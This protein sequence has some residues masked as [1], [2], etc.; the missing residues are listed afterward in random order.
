[1]PK[2]I[3]FGIAKA[4][5]GQP[6]TDRTVFTAFDQFIGTPAYMSPEQAELTSL[7]IDTRSDIYSLGVVMK[8]LEKDRARRY[9]T[10]NGL[11]ADL[12]R[13]LNNEPVVARPPSTAYLVKKY[14]RRHR[15][16]LAV[17]ASIAG[18]LIAGTS[19]STW[20]AIVATRAKT[21]AIQAKASEKAQRLAAQ[22]ERDKAQRAQQAEAQARQQ[23]DLDK[24]GARRLL[25]VA[26]M[27]LAQQAWE[28]NNIDRLRQLLEETKS[29]PDLGFE[30]FYWQR[31]MHLA[32]TTLRGHLETVRSAAFSPDGQRIVTASDDGAAIVWDTASGRQLLPL[33][34][35]KTGVRSVAFSPE[36]QRIVTGSWDTT[37]K[38]WEA[39][40]GQEFLTLTGHVASIRAVAFSPDSQ[41]IV[42]TSNGGTAMVWN[43]TSGEILLAVKRAGAS[44]AFSPDGQRILSGG[45]D[46]TIYDTATVWEAATGRE[47]LTLKG[48]GAPAAFSLD[49]QRIVTG[50]GGAAAKV[51]EAATGRELL[52]LKGH[53]GTVAAVAFSRDGQRIVTGSDDRTVRV[54]EAASG[55]E[56][57]MLQ[58]HSAPI[59]S[60]MFS[61]DGQRIVTGSRDH[62]AKVWEAGSD[63]EWFALN[64]H[65]A[66][67]NSAAFSPDGQRV[68]TGLDDRTAKVWEVTSGREL[69]AL[70]AHRAPVE[71]VAYS[72]D[73]QRILTGSEDQTA[74]VWEAASGREL[75]RLEGHGA[76][77]ESVAFSPD[78]Q[79]IVTG[80]EDQTARVWEVASGRELLPLKWHTGSI[81]SV[82][83]SPDGQRIVTGSVDQTA[84]VWQAARA[85]QVA[86]WQ[87]EEQ[88]AEQHLAVLERERTLKRERQRVA[89]IGDEGSIKRWLIL[90]PIPLSA[91]QS[92][93]Q[94]LDV[95]QI[96]GEAQ[97][98]PRMGETSAIG[99]REFKWREV[100]LRDYL[101]DSNAI[102]GHPT[103]RSVGY[104]VCY[105]RSDAEQHG[106]G[107]LVCSDTV[108]KV[109]L[110][111]EQVHRYA[112]GRS[113]LADQ[114][115]VPEVTLHAGLNVLVFKVVGWI[116]NW[117]GS[118]RFTD[119]QGNPVKGIKVTL[120]PEAK[121]RP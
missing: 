117:M 57:F 28:Q 74:R 110:N 17:V 58:G 47:L 55:R 100:A 50:G 20:Q 26:N 77:I 21:V 83:F 88:S 99:N 39:A 61:P 119:P 73:G 75:L 84:R 51:W 105:I 37:A 27:N 49:G 121:N 6:L 68:V 42:T 9:Q 120:D 114:D 118:V 29:F 94:G 76:P 78:G 79:R 91:G 22:T 46:N 45:F 106:L 98:R 24:A 59:L 87:A 115:E 43:A 8:C 35:H 66:G 5:A 97:F 41:R 52:E 107:M 23:A 54:W 16:A 14:V 71:C 18:L 80:S 69:R 63:R 48:A 7:D 113:Y 111:G 109:Y 67:I 30:W 89:R 108:S 96:V 13:H 72:P 62:T 95:E 104:A 10:A 112:I 82:A 93:Q 3:D 44:V 12:Q 92:I 32:L 53:S 102:Q 40:T 103:S 90:A 19:V 85:E 101:I 56:L 11:A 31:Q 34:G 33:K 15:T 60:V 1:V 64:G 4:T 70:Q 81:W 65:D 2:V 25:Y 38:V 86:A 36:G 116:G